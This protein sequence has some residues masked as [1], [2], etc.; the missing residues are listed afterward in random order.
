MNALLILLAGII[1]GSRQLD[2][3]WQLVIA[4]VLVVV[5]VIMGGLGAFPKA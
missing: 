5:G 3:R 2:T 4:V 1:I